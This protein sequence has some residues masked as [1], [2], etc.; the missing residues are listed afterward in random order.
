MKKTLLTTSNSTKSCLSIVLFLLFSESVIKLLIDAIPQ[1]IE[2]EKKEAIE[3][4]LTQIVQTYDEYND[5]S[6]DDVKGLKSFTDNLIG[7]Y[8]VLFVT[9]CKGSI[10]IILKCPTLQSLEHL[11]SDHLSGHLAKVAERY[12]VTDE[13][14]RNLNLETTCLRT[15]IDEENYLNCKK[16]LMEL[17]S[18]CSGEYK[19]NVW[20]VQLH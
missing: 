15:T 1:S 20:E 13:M 16:A 5:Y 8:R 17:P 3:Q 10:V 14:K 11:W 9:V 12:L 19:Q 2:K 4:V 6:R 7:T 18:T